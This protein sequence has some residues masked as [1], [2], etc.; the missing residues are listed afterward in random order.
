MT[1]GRWGAPPGQEPAFFGALCR[2]MTAGWALYQFLKDSE[3]T[4]EL[5]K[6]IEALP[7]GGKISIFTDSAFIPWEIVF[8]RYFVSE[9]REVPPTALPDGFEPE[10]LWG[11]RFEF[12]TVLMFS[13]PSQQVQN[14]LP[15]AR[16]QPGPLNIRIGVGSVEKAPEPGT[17]AAEASLN[18]LVHHRAYCDKNPSIAH[19][20]DGSAELRK[21]FSASNYDV[22]LLYLMCHGRSDTKGEELDFGAYKPVPAWLNPD[23]AYPGWPVVF[24][25]SCSIAGVSP[26]VFDT[27]LRRFREKH[28]F[29]LVASTFPLPT[30]FATL[31]GC[32]FLDGYRSGTRIG[33]VLLDLRRRLLEERNPLGFFYVLQCPLDIQAPDKP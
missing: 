33:Q 23:V 21:A 9:E 13:N 8:P 4:E 11:N 19:W 30:R 29:G 25:N 27:F 2:M 22:S 26:H 5:A 17:P 28:A 20:L 16:Q 24:I 18:A 3:A 12:E 14:P 1:P 6:A 31:F 32:E 10:L 15:P 7:N